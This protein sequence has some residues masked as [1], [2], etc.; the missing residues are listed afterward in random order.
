MECESCGNEVEED[1]L[2]MCCGVCF[3]CCAGTD[4]SCSGVD[5]GCECPCC[6][7]KE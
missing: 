5:E 7:E 1:E 3:D 4:H 2:C 6:N